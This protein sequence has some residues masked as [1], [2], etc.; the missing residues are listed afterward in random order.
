MVKNEVEKQVLNRV[1]LTPEYRKKIKEIIQEIKEKL[2]QEITKRK[3][4]VSIELVGSTAKDTYLK[5]NLDIDLFLIPFN[6]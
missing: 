3:L 1:T 5:D 6:D 2:Q 4:P